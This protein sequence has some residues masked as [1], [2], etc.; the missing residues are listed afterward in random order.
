[1]TIFGGIALTR[2]SQRSHR[3]DGTVLPGSPAFYAYRNHNRS[4]EAIY[5]MVWT[6]NQHV[7]T[8]GGGLLLRR[9]SGYQTAGRD[10]EYIF[11]GIIG[12][13][14]DSPD[15][16]RTSVD[17]INPVPSQPAFDRNYRYTQSD[18][19]AQDSFRVSPRLTL[20]YGLRY[21]HFG[22]PQNTG[23]VKDAMLS[24]GNGG[25]FNARLASATVGVQGTGNQQLFG[26]DNG[27]WAPRFGLSWDPFGKSGTIIRGG[28]GIFYDRLFDNLWQNV[29]NNRVVVPFY[30]LDGNPAN[31]LQSAAAALK[32]YSPATAD[33]PLLTLI[34]PKL[35]NGYS[36][37][38]FLGVQQAVGENLTVELNGTTALGRRLITT[39][40]V[41]R[42]FTTTE[43][44]GQ[45]N[46]ALPGVSWRSGQGLSDYYSLGARVRYRSRSLQT[47]V[48]YT[49]S[50]SID[51]QSDPLT[52]DFFDL[53]FT[54]L[55]SGGAN[56]LRSAFA[57]QFDS[58]SDR[59]NSAFDQRHNL[60]F[61][62]VWQPESR[63]RMARNW[64][65][66]LLSAFRTG[67]PYTV[68]AA[69]SDIPLSGGVIQNQRADLLNPGTAT[70]ATRPAGLG[71]VYLLNA[72]AFAAPAADSTGNTARNAFRGPGLHNADVSLA[73]SFRIPRLREG[74]LLTVRADA[75]NI[76]NHANLG[77]P[78]N[79]LG[80]LTFGLASYG[81]QGAP[82]GFPAV[83]PLNE[84]A[85]Q[86]QILLR[87]EF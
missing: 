57:R 48:S 81:R 21:E 11:S 9:N 27:D 45:P 76:L 39:D 32:I 37:T 30:F 49:W 58:R 38:G 77:N 43:G 2:K 74:S 17:R 84:T 75:F 19:F 80:S 87:V 29:R 52:G 23:S 62:A 51:N 7:I 18:F 42:D 85:R 8:A 6:R 20:N 22:A 33:F 63:W 73:R 35:R 40:L 5:S 41:N 34:D 66:S 25:N 24:L 82:S 86:I 46:P 60:F 16:F 10:S 4:L 55:N 54:S 72:A 1:M 50:H 61:L 15:T 56:T 65:V 78:D 67:T 36:Q 69:T 47:Q 13:G 3:D 26:S 79:L 83:A 68:L 14:F 28:F 59:G 31:Y 53:N 64:K 12:F 71:G 44:L 70:Y